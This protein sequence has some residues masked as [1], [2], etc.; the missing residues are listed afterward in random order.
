MSFTASAT[1]GA[2]PNPGVSCVPASGSL[3]AIGA[4][5]VSCTATDHV[6]N[7]ASGSFVV[8]VL[9]AREQLSRLIQKVVSASALPPALKTQLTAKLQALVGSFDP[10][11]AKQKQAVCVALTVFKGAVQAFSGRGIPPARAAEWIVDANRI[12]AVLAC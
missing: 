9:G 12:R 8:T 1:D 7:A 4:S 11:N 6:G 5:T 10:A 2:D 3:F